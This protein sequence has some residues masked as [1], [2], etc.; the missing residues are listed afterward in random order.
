MLDDLG[1]KWKHTPVQFELNRKFAHSHNPDVNLVTGPVIY[2]NYKLQ[3][4]AHGETSVYK[5][6]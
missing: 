6:V 3:V 4:N 2:D 5:R 1:Q